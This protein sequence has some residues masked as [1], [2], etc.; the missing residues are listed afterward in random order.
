[1]ALLTYAFSASILDLNT[2]C[3][4]EGSA[5]WVLYADL[6]CV[7][8]DGNIFDACVIG[9]MTALSNGRL[10]LISHKIVYYFLESK[11]IVIM[12]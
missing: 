6:V 4:H 10:I 11:S 8:Y 2:L 5:V 1:M 7:N 9:L 3:I 12:K